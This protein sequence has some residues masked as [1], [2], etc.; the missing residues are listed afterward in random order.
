[1]TPEQTIARA[2]R[3]RQLLE[4]ELLVG[5]LARMQDKCIKSW[6]AAHPDDK[7][8]RER[9]WWMVKG[10]DAFRGELLTLIGSGQIAA[11]DA[12]G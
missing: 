1:M 4:D 7:E 10:I 12:D 8:A 2:N 6:L 11:K 9:A 3:A 5:V